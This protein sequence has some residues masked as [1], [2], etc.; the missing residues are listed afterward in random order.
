MPGP[1]PPDPTRDAVVHAHPRSAVIAGLAGIEL[2]PVFGA[3]NI[4]AMRMA[5][6]GVPLYRRP[7]L[8]SR[9]ELADEMLSAM[10]DAP[11][12]L[13]LGHG[14]TVIGGT[15]EQATVRTVDLEQL[16]SVSV[17][18][19]RLGASPQAVSPADLV[20]LPDL[21]DPLNDDMAWDALAAG[22][23]QAIGRPT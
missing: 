15:V 4:P 23:D 8:I 9:A 13:L 19:A 18:L 20:E 17:E 7:V 6:A 10:G 21:G 22:L 12:C 5:I 14:V 16:C 2:R 3:Y 1:W 11:V